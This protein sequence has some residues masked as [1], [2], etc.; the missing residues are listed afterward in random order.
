MSDLLDQGWQC[1]IASTVDH[2]FSLMCHAIAERATLPGVMYRPALSVD[3]NQWCALY[4]SN[5]QDG[6][7]GFGD[8]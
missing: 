6:V 1:R 7:A 2:H 5:L 3:G 4:G 8:G